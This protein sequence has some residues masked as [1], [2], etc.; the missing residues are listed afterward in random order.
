MFLKYCILILIGIILFL[1]LNNKNI[2]G[3]YSRM[4]GVP[5]CYQPTSLKRITA[6]NFHNKYKTIDECQS[7]CTKDIDHINP[8]CI[9]PCAFMDRYNKVND[10]INDDYNK[11]FDF[12]YRIGTFKVNFRIDIRDAEERDKFRDNC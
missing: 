3:Y 5:D 8:S 10:F 1:L 7:E 9:I 6:T 4:F 11:F 12:L 2:E